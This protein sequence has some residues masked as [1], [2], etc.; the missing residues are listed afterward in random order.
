MRVPLKATVG[1]PTASG[2]F[3]CNGE[4]LQLPLKTVFSNLHDDATTVRLYNQKVVVLTHARKIRLLL[5]YAVTPCVNRITLLDLSFRTG[6]THCFKL[7]YGEDVFGLICAT[8]DVETVW[9]VFFGPILS[10]KMYVTDFSSQWSTI[11]KMS[12]DTVCR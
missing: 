1:V 5:C 6:V 10:S 8:N 4:S 12:C 9:S 7:I 2:C 3:T 11:P